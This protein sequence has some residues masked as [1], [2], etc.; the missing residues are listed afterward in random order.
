M[1]TGKAGRPEKVVDNALL[2]EVLTS[3]RNISLN[4]LALTLGIH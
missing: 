2:A 3:K 1:R 4:A